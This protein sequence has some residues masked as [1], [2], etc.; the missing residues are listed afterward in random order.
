MSNSGD[1]QV[2]DGW[3]SL[4]LSDICSIVG[5]GTPERAKPQY[6]KGSI[7]WVSPTEVTGLSTRYLEKTK[8]C[9]TEE[10]LQKSSA[11]LLPAGTVLMTSRASIGFPAI[12]KV[13]LTTNQGFQSLLCHEEK[14]Y[15]EFVYQLILFIRHDLERLAAGSTF[16][17][18]SSNNVKRVK[19][20]IPPLPEQKKIASILTSVDDVIEKIEAQIN[21]LQDLKKGMMTELLTKG[22]GHTEF[23]DSPVGRIP[24]EWEVRK[25]ENIAQVKGGKRLPKGRPFSD[26]PTEYPYIRIS[27]FRNGSVSCENIKYVYPKDR[28]H[29]KRYTISKDDICVSIAGAHLGLFVEI[30][31]QLDNALLTENAAKLIFE[32]FEKT[33]KTFVKYLCQSSIIQNQLM[34]EKGVGAGVPKLALFRISETILPLSSK[35]EQDKIVSILKAVDIRIDMSLEKLD[36]TKS[37]KKALMNDLLTGKKRV[38]VN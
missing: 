34:Q 18:I 20:S 24:V 21:K 30:P 6:W 37:L 14:S 9:I 33:N 26:K 17:E 36:R 3:K 35:S 2:P 31:Y 23:K 13:P 4:K 25:I 22:I 38:T 8:E 12:N 10:G 19:A 29:I 5:G 32:D 11:K 16:L 28:E 7:P 15:N 27:D 1:I